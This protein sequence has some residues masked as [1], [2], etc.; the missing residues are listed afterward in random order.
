MIRKYLKKF[1]PFQVAKAAEKEAP[2]EAV[3]PYKVSG[4]ASVFGELDA[5]G[6]VMLK[7]A[8][9]GETT[10][11]P[12]FLSHQTSGVPI[13]LWDAPK[14]SDKGL[15]VTGLLTKGIRDADESAL[16]IKAGSM[17]G[18]SVGG[19]A[20]GQLNKS[21]GIDIQKF[22][23]R[24]ITLTAFPACPGAEL[25]AQEKTGLEPSKN[26]AGGLNLDALNKLFT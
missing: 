21:G 7:G 8:F 12:M 13:G 18:L 24:E 2:T 22:E 20:I 17:G 4:L 11:I 26:A 23:L 19:W 1:Y 15:L 14:E 10:P 25:G 5:Y 6:D 16:A 3:D 9:A